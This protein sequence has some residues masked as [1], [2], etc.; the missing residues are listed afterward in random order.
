LGAWLIAV[1]PNHGRNTDPGFRAWSGRPQRVQRE[2]LER[3]LDRSSTTSHYGTL[4]VFDGERGG[5]LLLA[6]GGGDGLR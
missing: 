6:G 1:N 2:A 3:P 5:G 4:L